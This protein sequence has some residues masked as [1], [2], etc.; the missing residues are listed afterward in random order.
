MRAISVTGK[1]A[2]GF[3]L[4]EL[5]VVIAIIA[6]LA[7]VLSSGLNRSLPS[8]RV[9]VTADR[10]IVAV[11]EAQTS[12]VRSGVPVS[13][14]LEN[15]GFDIPPSTRVRLTDADGRPIQEVTLYP[16]GSARGGRF[17]IEDGVQRR[18]VMLSDL[19]GRVWSTRP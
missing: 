3:T 4:L 5:L 18:S 9:A 1:R 17:T 2:R 11:R 7:G 6:L 12:S 16:D 14:E 19:T 13:V 15:L 8:R 10:F